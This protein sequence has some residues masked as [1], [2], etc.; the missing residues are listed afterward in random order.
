MEHVEDV[1]EPFV[2]AVTADINRCFSALFQGETAGEDGQL[3]QNH[4]W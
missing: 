3:L 4:I 2:L 1:I